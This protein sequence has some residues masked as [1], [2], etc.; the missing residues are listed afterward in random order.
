MLTFAFNAKLEGG[1]DRR[2][3]KVDVQ[4]LPVQS[5]CHTLW[6]QTCF[7]AE[8]AWAFGIDQRIHHDPHSRSA[9]VIRVCEYDC[10]SERVLVSLKRCLDQ[11]IGIVSNLANHEARTVSPSRCWWEKKQHDSISNR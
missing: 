2:C 10:I 9:N 11:A 8:A 7:V 1:C 4:M 6:S 3:F 5:R